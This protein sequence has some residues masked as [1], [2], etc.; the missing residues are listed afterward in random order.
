M[1]LYRRSVLQEIQGPQTGHACRR[2]MA[3]REVPRSLFAV[4]ADEESHTIF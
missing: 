4:G 1:R 3:F 2:R